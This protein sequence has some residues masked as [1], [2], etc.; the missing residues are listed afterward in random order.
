MGNDEENLGGG[1][2]SNMGLSGFLN[3]CFVES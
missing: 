3:D 2:G 1:I